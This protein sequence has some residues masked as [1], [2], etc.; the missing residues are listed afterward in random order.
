M[1][2]GPRLEKLRQGLSEKK[3]DGVLNTKVTE[4][5]AKVLRSIEFEE[6]FLGLRL[7]EVRQ[8]IE[9]LKKPVGGSGSNP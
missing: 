8:M 6:K 1:S 5:T 9:D 7:A 3:L 4:S 2:F